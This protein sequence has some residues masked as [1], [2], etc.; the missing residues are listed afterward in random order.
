[1]LLS[2][3]FQARVS[4]LT[5]KQ[6]GQRPEPELFTLDE[7]RA[8]VQAAVALSAERDQGHLVTFDLAV[9]E[10][11]GGA[12]IRVLFHT[13]AERSNE[14]HPSVVQHPKPDGQTSCL[15]GLTL[16]VHRSTFLLRSQLLTV[17]R[18]DF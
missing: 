8:A 14:F 12:A 4:E 11:R 10:R 15:S 3:P 2:C 9:A 5:S 6:L 7:R 1:M 16:D 17:P 18:G 13:M